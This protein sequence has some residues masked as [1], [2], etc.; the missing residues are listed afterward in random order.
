MTATARQRRIEDSERY[1]IPPY[2]DGA[3]GIFTA[4]AIVLLLWAWFWFRNFASLQPPQFINVR[5]HEVAG[6]NENA[7]VFVDGVRLGIVD[8]IEWQGMH[9]V[10]VRIRVTSS[11]LSVPF[12]SRFSILSNGVVGAKYIDINLPEVTGSTKLRTIDAKTIVTGEDPVRPELAIN[13]V[14]AGLDKVDIDKIRQHLLIDE[15]RLTRAAEDLSQL[16]RKASPAME[17][18]VPLESELT[19]LSRDLRGVSRRVT[20]TLDKAG[21]LESELTGLTKDLRGVSQRLTKTVDNQTYR[22]DLRYVLTKTRDTL[23]HV[24]LAARQMN[25]ILDKKHP[26][27]HM[28]VGRPGH[29]KDSDDKEKAKDKDKEEKGDASN[30]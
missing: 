21:P 13:H 7:A 30:F 11:K 16:A 19:G 9:N 14:A 24:D 27:F 17:R 12:G 28:M 1:D 15:E 5:F 23:D 10:V 29:V 20:T 2:S 25:Q 18:A 8:K 6:L 22:S 26:L 4:V 3:L